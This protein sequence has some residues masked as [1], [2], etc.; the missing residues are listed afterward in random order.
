MSLS[1]GAIT[2]Q[3]ASI[4]VLWFVVQTKVPGQR[5][6]KVMLKRGNILLYMFQLKMCVFEVV[7]IL[8]HDRKRCTIHVLLHPGLILVCGRLFLLD[9][10]ISAHL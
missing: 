1:S 6:F 5:F 8:V 7:S 10:F 3:I 4:D 9:G 2:G